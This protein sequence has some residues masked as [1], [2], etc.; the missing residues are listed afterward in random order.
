M[1]NPPQDP[2]ASQIAQALV[3]F[4]VHG[5]FPEETASSLVINSS[6]LPHAIEVL[7]KAKSQLQTQVHAINE[8]T[9]EDVHSWQTNAQSAQ[10]DIIRSKA[11][12]NEILKIS[13]APA[14]SGKAIIEAE[15]KADFLVRELNYNLQVQNALGGIRAVSQTLDRVEQARD[16]RRILDALHLLEK[17]WNELDVIPVDKSCRAIRLLD[18]RAFELKSD[19]HEVFDHVWKSLVHVD[20]DNQKI[21]IISSKQDESMNL[22]DA[23]IGLK[24]YKEVE[25]RTAKLWQDVT[26]AILLPRM[27]TTKA[28]LPSVHVDGNILEIRGTADNSVDSLF[29][30]LEQVFSFL[31]QRL[32]S[33]LV[34]TISSTLLPEV[35]HRVTKVWL[36]SAVPASLRDM[37]KFQDVIAVAKRFCGTLKSLGFSNFGDLQEWTESAPRVWLSKCR[38]AAL[39]SVRT[40][41]S[42]G[43][44]TSTRVERIEKQMVSRS[45]G[46]QLA[47]NG[48]TTDADDHGW[49]AWDDGEEDTGKQTGGIEEKP[50][51]EG[52]DDDDGTD[53]WGWGEED[54]ELEEK[55]E[56][57]AAGGAGE[58]EDPTEAWGWGEETNNEEAEVESKPKSQSSVPS[59]QARELTFKESYSISS[60]P[61]PVLDLIFAI[62]EDG[63]ALTQDPYAASPVAAAAAGLFSLPTLV[64]AMFRAVSPYY[65]APDIG[66]NMYLYNDAIYLSQQLKEYAEA[67][68]KRDDITARA[69]NMLR[70]DMDIKSLQS[71]ANRAYSNEMNI[72]KRVLRDMLGGDHSLMHQDDTESSVSSAVVRV[73]AMAIAWE[74][75]L[76]RSAWQQAIG[77]LADAVAAKIVADVMDMTSIGQE[78][79]YTIAELIA[80]VAD[81]DDLFLPSRFLPRSATGQRKSLASEGEAG[82]I[83][84]TAQY[85]ASWLRLKYL[86]EV[87]QS[88]LKDVRFLW[89]ESELSL[90]FSVAEV[91][92][93]IN[94]SFEDNPRTRE[95]IKEILQNPSPLGS[96]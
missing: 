85:A 43:L 44:G 56:E 74:D 28:R 58:D 16:E 2:A 25:Q 36:D 71:F 8:E 7:A 91:V 88:N 31:V 78:E 14:V 70:L 35:I 19:V 15:A 26:K 87:L 42:Q 45:E 94:M 54:A 22:T 65:Y 32:P 12:A 6:V 30:D 95:V 50:Q 55:P 1:A 76:S 4:S 68:R 46:Q 48:A 66:G 72:Q 83:P 59:L 69:Q 61:Q 47:A 34:D 29:T 75:I 10:D 38:E 62:V 13:E 80:T 90:Y 73:R 39:D 64:L 9:A 77:S 82:E 81:L 37:N 40:K 96:G 92:E 51:S 53:A 27:D 18:I 11:L 5:S 63:A 89:V 52:D 57:P 60:M 84:T 3:D 21:S 79:A 24:A 23:V 20:I 33:D 67:W 17:S 49:D 41:L 93:L 86:S